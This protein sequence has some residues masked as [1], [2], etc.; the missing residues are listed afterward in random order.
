MLIWLKSDIYFFLFSAIVFHFYFRPVDNFNK[1]LSISILVLNYWIFLNHLKLL[2]KIAPTFLQYFFSFLD[3]C[4]DLI[5]F[6]YWR[7]W[8]FSLWAEIHNSCPLFVFFFYFKFLINA[9]RLL[10]NIN[11]FK[12]VI[13]ICRPP[14]P[15]RKI[16]TDLN[17]EGFFLFTIQKEHTYFDVELTWCTNYT[18]PLRKWSWNYVLGK[19]I[20]WYIVF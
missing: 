3:S 17:V 2:R 6:L 12:G 11:Q 13:K 9:P 18:K 15:P 8:V 20:Y 10:N 7:I 19:T 5:W 14:P 16:T 1:R 4:L